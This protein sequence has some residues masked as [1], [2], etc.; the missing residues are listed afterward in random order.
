MAK[1]LIVEDDRNLLDTLKYNIRKEGYNT[2]VAVDGAEALDVVAG[3]SL[4]SSFLISCSPSSV[5]LRSVAS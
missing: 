3:K 1:I 5:A 2:F 4:I